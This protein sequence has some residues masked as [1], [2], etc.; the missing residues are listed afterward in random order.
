M[1]CSCRKWELTEI[2]CKHVVVAYW[3]MALNGQQ[4]PSS[5]AWANPCYWLT[6]LREIYSNKVEPITRRSLHLQQHFRHR[7]L[8][9][10]NTFRHKKLQ[11]LN[12][13]DRTTGRKQLGSTEHEMN[14]ASE[15]SINRLREEEAQVC[16]QS[17]GNID[18]QKDKS[19]ASKQAN[20]LFGQDDSG[21]SVICDSSGMFLSQHK[22]ST[23]TLEQA[24]MVN[25][26]PS[27][28]PVDTESKHGDDGDPVSDPTLYRSLEGSLQYLTFT[29]QNISYA[30]QHVTLDHGLQLFSSSTT[31]V[32]AYSDADW[33]GC[34]TT[35][36]ST[37][38]YCIFIGNNL[39]SWSSKRQRTLSRS[40]AELRPEV[41]RGVCNVGG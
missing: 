2:P 20:L 16:I 33:A 36:R 9:L 25:C 22:Y 1:T 35:R 18:P 19:V 27:R 24:P 3:N 4:V 29:R 12:S 8:H 17:G 31:Y 7:S 23:N 21:I 37:S 5:Q 32:A 26:N 41:S 38:G 14:L 11:G 6:T 40:S 15:T 10:H 13:I 28:T 30:M 39:L 34:P